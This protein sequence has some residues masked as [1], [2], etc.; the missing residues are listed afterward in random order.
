MIVAVEAFTGST[1]A[2]TLGVLVATLDSFL[3]GV[4]TPVAFFL[5][6]FAFCKS[7]EEFENFVKAVEQKE[8]HFITNKRKNGISIELK[9]EISIF[10]NDE[11]SDSKIANWYKNAFNEFADFI[12]STPELKWKINVA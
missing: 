1:L 2:A 6:S 3:A 11:E 8:N 4:V 12:K 10:L 9:K 5:A 7:N